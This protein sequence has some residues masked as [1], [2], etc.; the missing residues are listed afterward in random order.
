MNKENKETEK[1]CDIHGVSNT[2]GKL[3]CDC[4]STN[5]SFTKYLFFKC[6]DCK[7]EWD[8]AN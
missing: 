6:H 4:G 2:E 5:V 3:V 7:N 8:E 1:Q